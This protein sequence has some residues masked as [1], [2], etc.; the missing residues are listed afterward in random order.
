MKRYSSNLIQWLDG[1]V[2]SLSYFR[3]RI[4]EYVNI[5]KKRDLIRSVKI[6][7]LDVQR[8][9]TLWKQNY[10]STIPLFWHQLYASYTGTVDINYFPEIFY[11]TI[12]ERRYND[13]YA[14]LAF[15][16]KSM[17]DIA[18][19]IP[20]ESKAHT[21]SS[22]FS[23]TKGN[24]YDSAH[25]PITEDAAL[26]LIYSCGKCVIKPSVD[27]D[28]GLG[29]RVLNCLDGKDLKTGDFLTEVINSYNQDF[30]VQSYVNAHDTIKMLNPSSLNTI[31]I[32]TY[33]LE[34]QVYHCPLA[35]RIGACNSD[36]DNIHAGG[37]VIGLSDEGILN[38]I[39]FSE[40]GEKYKKHP[41]TGIVFAG[42]CI[43]YIRQAIELVE[44]QH[45]LV[46]RLS[47]I[48]WDITISDNGKPIIVEM[49]TRNQSA[50]FPQM[51][52][53]RSLFGKNTE[54]MIRLLKAN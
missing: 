43:P 24:F 23:K 31:R 52:N 46:P 12:L 2:V 16:D 7:S 3:R 36:V 45:S 41:V 17:L 33:L 44:R 27:T 51:V 30:L 21:I 6:D 47:F 10:G 5:W 50:W 28:S 53:G 14:A 26:R 54:K 35:M 48:S 42:Y 32:I 18:L 37:L 1:R 9:Q 19:R 11:S 40:Y 22:I 20:G 25:S 38:E 13:P 4:G 8:I 39:A 49:N 34:G 29:V 15:E